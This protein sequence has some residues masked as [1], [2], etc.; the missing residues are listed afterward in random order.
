MRRRHRAARQMNIERG[1]RAASLRAVKANRLPATADADE[2]AP[3]QG[4]EVPMASTSPFITAS[5]TEK[6]AM[7]TMPTTKA[8]SGVWR[9]GIM[10]RA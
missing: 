9:R 1:A 4:G 8:V 7:P 2:A 6:K 3:Q 10:R 5:M